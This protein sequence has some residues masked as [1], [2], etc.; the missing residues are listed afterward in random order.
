MNVKRYCFHSASYHY[1]QE[2]KV[3]LLISY[4]LIE[5][6]DRVGHTWNIN[7]WKQQQKECSKPEGRP[8]LCNELQGSQGYMCSPVSIPL[9]IL[10]T[11]TWL[12]SLASPVILL[13]YHIQS[14]VYP[15][16]QS[17]SSYRSLMSSHVLFSYPS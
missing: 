4:I 13:F 2:R 1:K 3:Q 7:T 8:R 6:V 9:L 14:T 16:R 11:D 17:E 15:S 5:M 12:L 10:S